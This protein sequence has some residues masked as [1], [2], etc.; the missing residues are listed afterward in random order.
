MSPGVSGRGT[1]TAVP[2][3]WH[4]PL[5][6]RMVM[7]PGAGKVARDFYAY[8]QGPKAGEIFARHGFA[9]S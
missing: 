6:Q 1:F 2:A 3:R 9:G 4:K 5:R 7:L 8:L